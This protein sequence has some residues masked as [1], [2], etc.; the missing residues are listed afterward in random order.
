MIMRSG[1]FK[2]QAAVMAGICFLAAFAFSLFCQVRARAT[3]Q[4]DRITLRLAHWQLE[5][6]ARQ[7]FDRIAN[8]YMQLHPGVEII[9]IP[10]PER[11]YRTWM[12]TQFAGGTAPDLVE[13]LLD[14]GT[15]DDRIARF[16]TPLSDLAE[17]PNPYDRGTDLEG[18]P[19]RETFLDGMKGGYFDN[20]LDYYAVPISCPTVR[21]YYNLDLLERITGH[22]TPPVDYAGFMDLCRRT[23]AYA[24]QVQPD[25]VPIAGSRAN[26]LA[27][28]ISLFNSQTQRLAARLAPA[29]LIYENAAEG[30]I[31]RAADFL[32]GRWS[33]DSPEVRAGFEMMRAVGGEMQSGFI[34][35]E[36]DE[37]ARRFASGQALMINTGSWNAWSLRQQVTFP[38]GA[39][40]LPYPS[41]NDP[42]YGR[43]TLGA[44][45]ET[46]IPATGRF[47]LTRNSKHPEVAKDFLRFLAS[48]QANQL[49]TNVS[50]WPPAIIGTRVSAE[51]APFLPVREGY[52][53]G[54]PPSISLVGFREVARCCDVNIHRLLG[55]HGSTEAF[56]N[57]LKPQYGTAVQAD[58]RRIQDDIQ[59][60]VRHRDSQFAALA[61]IARG[62]PEKAAARRRLDRLL[63]ADSLVERRSYQ[64]KLALAPASPPGLAGV[65]A[66]R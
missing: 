4:T 32:H 9:Q 22:P 34:Q 64:A 48:R 13:I 10:I 38:V 44:P 26:G 46:G 15:S 53:A 65:G 24:A 40:P 36:R 56:V 1:R 25:L 23:T 54:F 57:A 66:D 59:N 37:A 41:V 39:G 55:P 19:L 2:Q 35:T 31:R 16:F 6:G 29:G 43:F 52:V 12:V 7:A 21:M 20:L 8:A 49:W 27:L 60:Q 5:T 30:S 62:Q 45:S 28:M 42:D 18:L 11:I 63:Q 17:A 61:W 51:I 47:G 14:A 50:G 58:L 33:L 3:G